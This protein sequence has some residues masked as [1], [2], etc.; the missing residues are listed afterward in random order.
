MNTE[1]REYLKAALRLRP[2]E[3]TPCLDEDQVVAFYSGEL[4][5]DEAES[6]R[7]HLA[8]CP[9][10]LEMARDARG[11]L[12]A[13]SEPDQMTAAT[14]QPVS[15]RPATTPGSAH[16]RQASWWQSLLNRFQNPVVGFSMAMATLLLAIGCSFLIVRTWQLHNQIERMNAVAT[17]LR[18][19]EQELGRQLAEQT[20]NQQL[21]EEMQRE[22]ELAAKTEQAGGNKPEVARPVIASL[23]LLPG[24]RDPGDANE[25]VIPPDANLIRLQAG[26][27]A[28]DYPIYYASLRTA[29]GAEV[30][31]R[32]G[33]K[34]QPSGSGKA[35]VCHLPPKVFT[36][37]DYVLSISGLTKQGGS[38]EVERYSFR[39]SKKWRREDDPQ[40]SRRSRGR[41]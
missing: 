21:F 40:P 35:V 17:Q 3:L 20:R 33:L 34:A 15:S 7:N 24:F 37:R 28:D 30:W 38:E 2:V 39:V 25:L 11:F 19:Q 5:E 36:K 13:M 6:V 41:S 9:D 18:Q 26:L 8:E 22:W 32:S 12:K 16:S 10:C 31:I 23:V 27:E 4:V 1:E 29:D 14:V